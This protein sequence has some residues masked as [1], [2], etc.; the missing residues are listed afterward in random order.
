MEEHDLG[1]LGAAGR[2]SSIEQRVSASERAN[3]EV[4]R[5]GTGREEAVGARGRAGD[6]VVAMSVVGACEVRG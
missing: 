2:W 6:D 4:R 3:P 1:P 5:G